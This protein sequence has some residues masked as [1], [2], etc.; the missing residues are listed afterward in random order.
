[1]PRCATTTPF[2]IAHEFFDALPIHAFTA[3]PSNPTP[4]LT[5]STTAPTPR[6]KPSRPEWR[7]LVISPTAPPSK[8]N[9]PK[10][11]P[12][13]FELTLSKAPTRHST[14]LPT[15]SPRYKALAARP[16]AT[17]EISPESRIYTADIAQRIGGASPH[18]ARLHRPGQPAPFTKTR[19]S[20]AALIIDYGPAATIPV[21]TLRGI[22][23]HRTVSPFERPGR[24]DLTAD[25][26]FGA[27][28]E[29]ALSASE[30]VV[31][32]GPTT[33]AGWLGEMGGQE[34]L[35]RLMQG[36]RGEEE[37]ERVRK[38][39]ERLVDRGPDGMGRVY[40]CLAIVAERGPEGRRVVGFG[41]D[42][43]A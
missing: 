3:V 31:V 29:T 12:P 20:G 16:G 37:K 15:L 24:V 17:I 19:P 36:A 14:L 5:T 28:V 43:G 4:T 25:V 6:P 40:K 1:M 8:L 9:P 27:I 35:E 41:G 22:S 32:H 30:G 39:W 7:E 26:D 2:I 34:R 38:G 42:V 21:N 18:A 10:S 11:P 13:E 23:A 33:Q